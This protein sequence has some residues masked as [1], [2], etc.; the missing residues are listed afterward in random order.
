MN[1]DLS[2]QSFS[3]S[4]LFLLLRGVESVKSFFLRV[5]RA[6]CVETNAIVPAFR[7]GQIQRNNWIVASIIVALVSHENVSWLSRGN[8]RVTIFNGVECKREKNILGSLIK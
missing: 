6:A 1:I 5:I 4:L 7:Q 8:F 3:L 2:N